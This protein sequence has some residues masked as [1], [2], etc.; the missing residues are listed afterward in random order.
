MARKTEAIR[1]RRLIWM[2]IESRNAF[3]R[4]LLAGLLF[5]LL[6]SGCTVFPRHGANGPSRDHAFIVHWPAPEHSQLVRLAIK[7][8]IDM[9]GVVTTAGSEYFAKNARPATR[10][11][12]CLAI[13]RRRDIH[14]VGKVNLSE[15]AVAPS[16]INDYFGTPRNPFSG[17]R[18]LIPGG[19]SCGSA[20]VV[21]AKKADIAFGTDTAGSIRIPAACCGVVGLKTTFGLVSLD[22]VFPIEPKHLDT[23]GPL[24]R[25][26]D[27][28]AEGMD[29]LQE[30]FAARYQKAIATRRPAPLIKIGRLTL[31]GT[32]R[33]IDRAVDAALARAG[34]QVVPLGDA[35]RRK[36]EQAHRDGTAVA[37][38]GAWIS[39]RKYAIKP[40]VSARTKSIIATGGVAYATQYRPSLRRRSEWQ[41][42][43]SNAFEKVDF[44]ALPTLQATPPKFPPTLRV[45]L[46]KAKLHVS[47]LQNTDALHFAL[48]PLEAVA[49]VPA[50]G[51]RLLGIDLFEADMLKL[52][53]TVAVNL[54][55]NPALA[56]PIPLRHGH[57]PVTSLQLIGRP[58]SE[59]EVLAAGR[60]IEAQP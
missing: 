60:L 59:A 16:G 41:R 56:M 1:A 5:A 49:F 18:K 57:V 8:N 23:V 27:G 32:D 45:D 39:D 11:A 6:A 4:R 43:L 30:G 2:M 15:F 33:K 54:A 10:D 31:R 25:N 26:I 51:L 17:W 37:A 40:G 36:W 13:A 22:G 19:S 50:T 55:G 42:T 24:A 38:A 29:L 3:V 58:M 28:V 34:F 35:F 14:I 21:A 44:I 48:N 9:Q 52:Q 46:L 47:H 7:D 12:A 53:N 20:Y